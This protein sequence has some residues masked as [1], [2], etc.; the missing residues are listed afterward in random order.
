MTMWS[1]KSKKTKKI[2]ELTNALESEKKACN[3]LMG[4]YENLHRLHKAL[5]QKY[6]KEQQEADERINDLEHQLRK[7]EAEC[8]KYKNKLKKNKQKEDYNDPRRK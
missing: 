2:E 3:E 6:Q 8:N 1:L 4:K 5:W 7:M